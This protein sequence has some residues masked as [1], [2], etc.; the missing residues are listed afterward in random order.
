MKNLWNRYSYA[1][2]LV[3]LS[4]GSA[5]IIYFQSNSFHKENYVNITIAEGDSLW[6]I[7]KEYSQTSSFSHDQ[8]ISWVKKHNQIEGDLI[9]PGEKIAIPV[10]NN[11]V[12]AKEFASAAK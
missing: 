9:Y 12:G 3:I 8:F 6:K 2:I 7:A 11:E 4:F 10:K 1:I 5:L